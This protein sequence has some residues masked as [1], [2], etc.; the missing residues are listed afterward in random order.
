MTDK[1]LGQSSRTARLALVALVLALA[2]AAP[3]RAQDADT[4]TPAPSSIFR[5]PP[6]DDGRAPGVQGPAD[7]GLPPVAPNERR[8]AQQSAPTP[9]PVPPR[10]T[11]T[12]PTTTT[13]P[14]PSTLTRRDTA[15][16]DSPRTAPATPDAAPD[17]A[18]QAD[19]ALPP[20]QTATSQVAPPTGAAA[21]ERDD[22]PIAATPREAPSG[23]PLWAWILTVLAA[24][25]AGLWYWRRRPA[26]AGPAG[27]AGAEA[28]RPTVPPSAPR[29]APAPAPRPTPARPVPARSPAEPRGASPLVT[30]VAGEQRA[31]V[32]MTLDI[33]SIRFASDHVAVGFALHLVNQGT[34]PATGLMVRIAL[35]QGSAMPE[36]VLGRF[37]DGAGGSVLRDDMMLG[38]GAGEELSTEVMLPR[39]T[40]EPLLIG[41][42]P[43]LVPVIAFDVTYHW[44]GEG[45]AF[46]QNA[47]SFVLGREQ[48]GGGSDKLAP[49]PLDRPSYL[50]DRPGVRATAVKRAQ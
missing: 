13:A 19:I 49:L 1:N 12:Q 22:P 36:S 32:A 11:P 9:S 10:V 39:A 44:D 41:G 47:S 45:D 30:R 5:L 35:N 46:G 43:M 17:S 27:D 15:A 38:V 29:A 40:I 33:R 37:F 25:G 20:P 14:P 24:L 3:A 16:P 28:P 31:L 34:L 18:G 4:P 23:T 6:A 7:N 26:L 21:P 50:V 8:G 2:S 48:D 42:K